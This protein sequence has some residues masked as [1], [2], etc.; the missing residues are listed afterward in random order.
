MRRIGTIF[1]AIFCL[2][3][4]AQA[5]PLFD[6]AKQGDTAT[7]EALLEDGISVD[8]RG[9]NQATPLI[10][11]AL[12]GNTEAAAALIEAGAD[13]MARNHSGFTPLHAAA[14]GGHVDIARLLLARGADVNGRI[15]RAEKSPI[16][17]AADEGHI[18]V[19]ELLLDHDADI[20]TLDNE[21]FTVLIRTM[22]RKHYDIVAF[23]KQ[24]GA[25]CPPQ[26]AFG[27]EFHRL[28]LEAGK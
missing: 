8:E 12:T 15:N 14:Y 10:A 25:T 27:P 6:A 24:H 5:G 9:P 18:E 26:D 21:G 11:A 19:I 7:V 4:P 23:L 2:L 13:V 28:C 22:F 1:A 20:V 3:G 16:F 17:L